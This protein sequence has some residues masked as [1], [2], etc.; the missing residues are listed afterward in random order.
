MR[1][2]SA[3]PCARAAHAIIWSGGL[4]HL[5]L[6]LKPPPQSCRPFLHQPPSDQLSACAAARAPHVGKSHPTTARARRA[7]MEGCYNG[8]PAAVA[9]NQSATYGSFETAPITAQAQDLCGY[10]YLF[11]NDRGLLE[12]YAQLGYYYKSY[13]DDVN[14]ETGYNG[15]DIETLGNTGYNDVPNVLFKD[16][17]RI[18]AHGG[19]YSELGAAA[20]YVPYLGTILYQ[21]MA[22][23]YE[24]YVVSARAAVN[25]AHVEGCIVL[26]RRRRDSGRCSR[27]A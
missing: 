8:F 10:M 25:P 14:T 27:C 13:A 20:G 6:Q 26:F 19:T 23:A 9:A 7:G 4:A 3:T 2:G 18:D 21:N 12:Q 1:S 22:C 11:N 16:L 24:H 5:G 15:F 17:G